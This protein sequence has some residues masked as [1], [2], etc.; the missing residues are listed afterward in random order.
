[1]DYIEKKNLNAGYKKTQNTEMQFY[2][3]QNIYDENKKYTFYIYSVNE[4]VTID[5]KYFQ[6]LNFCAKKNGCTINHRY[7]TLEMR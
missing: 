4:N 1:M 6:C 7:N 2:H 3:K 5:K